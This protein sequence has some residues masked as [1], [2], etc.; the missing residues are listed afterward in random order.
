MLPAHRLAVD[1]VAERM[2]RGL[3]RQAGT[4]EVPAVGE[5]R[6]P[7]A[8]GK[9]RR[10]MTDRH[11]AEAP[12]GLDL[13]DHRPEGVEVGDDGARRTAL[14]AAQGGANGAAPG[15]LIGNPKRL[16]AARG[17]ARH[18]VGETDRTRDGEQLQ[19]GFLEIGVVDGWQRR[20][21]LAAH[22][23]VSSMRVRGNSMST[24]RSA[25]GWGS[26][27]ARPGR[28]FASMIT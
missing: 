24:N 23:V 19:Q 25:V 1:L 6:E 14:A 10:P 15:Q 20:Q 5:D 3:Q 4:A 11:H 27:L 18:A 13:P 16:E 26:W 9:T 12:V 22:S 2:T 7:A 8:F 21:G 17:V 28:S